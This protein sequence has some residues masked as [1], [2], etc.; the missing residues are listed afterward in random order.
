LPG[1]AQLVTGTL[2]QEEVSWDTPLPALPPDKTSSALMFMDSQSPAIVPFMD[3][4]YDE[5]GT[6]IHY[7]GAGAGYRDFRQAPSIF[8]E[9]GFIQHGGLLILLPLD[10]TVNVRHGWKRVAGPFIASRASGKVIHELNWETAGDLY[11]NEVE[12]LAPELKGKPVFPDLTSRFPLSIGKQNAE[13]VVR[14]PF[15]INDKGEILLLS[16]V[17]ENSAIYISEGNKD[18]LIDAAQQAVSDCAGGAEVSACFVSDCYSRA[19]ML[20][21]DLEIEL[22]RVNATLNQFTNTPVQGVLAIGEI[23]GNGRTNLES[24]NKTFV[25]ALIH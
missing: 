3:A 1:D 20:G 14:D 9:N 22:E 15:G 17:L 5:Y 19:L 7:A 25:I 4:I 18:T 11:R 10:L 2:G 13:D 8:S 23:C 21:D 24:Y 12:A 6:T 16:D